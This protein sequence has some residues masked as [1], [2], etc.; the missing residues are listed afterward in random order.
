L[1]NESTGYGNASIREA[2]IYQLFDLQGLSS[3]FRELALSQV[4]LAHPL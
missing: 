1:L 2:I 4:E 3:N